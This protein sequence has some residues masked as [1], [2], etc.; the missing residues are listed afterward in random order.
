MP[1][2][3]PSGGDSTGLLGAFGMKLW[4]L[5]P[6]STET[7]GEPPLNSYVCKTGVAADWRWAILDTSTHIS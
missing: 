2:Y 5:L 7:R 4:A 1:S 3:L 6:H